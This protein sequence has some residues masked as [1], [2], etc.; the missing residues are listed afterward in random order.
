MR[1]SS[2]PYLDSERR[3]LV[4][5]RS[6]PP[7]LDPNLLRRELQKTYAKMA[8]FPRRRYHLNLGREIALRV[9]YSPDELDAVPA[10]AVDTFSGAGNPL[11]LV[12]LRPGDAVLDVGSGGGLDALLA[13]RRVGSAGRVVGVDLTSEMVRKARETARQARAKNLTFEDGI[14][15]KLPFPADSFDVVIANNVVNNLCVDKAA[16]LGEIDRVLRPGGAFA[17]A[18]VVVQLPIPDDGRADISLWTG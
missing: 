13:A 6:A 5:S 14:A 4:L 12:D 1:S 17:V 9:G 16:A 3:L 7:E 10:A 2:R 11:A 15:E 18:D 8:L